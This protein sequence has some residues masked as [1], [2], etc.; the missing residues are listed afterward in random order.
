MKRILFVVF[1]VIF[2]AASA[3][4]EPT[5]TLRNDFVVT[6]RTALISPIVLES[7]EQVT[8]DT[9]RIEFSNWPALEPKAVTWNRDG[10]IE[11]LSWSD[12]MFV[13]AKIAE[14][15][16]SRLFPQIWELGESRVYRH[17]DW[18]TTVAATTEPLDHWRMGPSPAL[19][20]GNQAD[21]KFKDDGPYLSEILDGL[22][23][24]IEKLEKKQKSQE[25]HEWNRVPGTLEVLGTTKPCS[26]K[27]RSKGATLL[28]L[29]PQEDFVCQIC[30]AVKR[31]TVSDHPTSETVTLRLKEKCKTCDGVGTVE[32]QW[33]AKPFL[34]RMVDG[35]TTRTMM[36]RIPDNSLCLTCGGSGYVWR[37]VE[38]IIMRKENQ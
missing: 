6:S 29:P 22:E 34:F 24:R 16:R 23:K 26:H 9:Y 13:T 12:R 28:S 10:T 31:E 8:S 38:A 7:I 3:A 5:G 18:I 21:F 2:L 36:V 35:W 14:P 19:P 15:L 11:S 25:P 27:W 37:E 17:G 1:V 32:T 30:G 20:F 33:S 4:A